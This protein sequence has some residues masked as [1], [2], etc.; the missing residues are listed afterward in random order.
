MP[1]YWALGWIVGTVQ[2]HSECGRAAWLCY[3]RFMRSILTKHDAQQLSE[4]YRQ[5]PGAAWTAANRLTIVPPAQALEGAD[6]QR[7]LEAHERLAELLERMRKIL[8]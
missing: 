7:F 4:L 1:V 5:V 3:A 6:L 8:G 2:R